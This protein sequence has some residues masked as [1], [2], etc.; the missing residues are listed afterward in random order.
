MVTRTEREASAPELMVID[1][2]VELLGGARIIQSRLHGPLDVHEALSRGL[3]R[4]ALVHLIGNV[5]VLHDQALVKSAIGVSLRT[6]QRAKVSPG[7]TLNREQSGRL[8]KF[9]EILAKAAEVL[10]SQAAA[11]RWLER[12]AIGLDQR[13]PIDLLSTPVGVKL[14]EDLLGRIEYGVYA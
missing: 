9:A 2:T 8:W 5:R 1:R 10:G 14:V 3:P 13:R 12:P 4:E 7:K 11:E 6:S